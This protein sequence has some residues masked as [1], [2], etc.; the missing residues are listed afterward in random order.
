MIFKFDSETAVIV[1]RGIYDVRRGGAVLGE[2]IPLNDVENRVIFIPV[3][4][5][6]WNI[7]IRRAEQ[8]V[9]PEQN[10]RSV[11]HP[12]PALHMQSQIAALDF[13]S[14]AVDEFVHWAELKYLHVR[15]APTGTQRF[16]YQNL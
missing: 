9:S 10:S 7:F 5:I 11:H 12:P 14:F 6:H 2:P 16:A 13:P 4:F 3:E 8:V 15:S 1:T